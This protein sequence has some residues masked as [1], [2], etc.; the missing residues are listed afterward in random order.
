MWDST[1]HEAVGTVSDLA[2]AIERSQRAPYTHAGRIVVVDNVA[3][4]LG[5]STA[6]L[7]R[8]SQSTQPRVMPDGL[9]VASAA[10]V[11]PR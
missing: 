3:L 8:T 7:A 4:N 2:S 9:I 5:A 10:C 11:P 1:E 6:R